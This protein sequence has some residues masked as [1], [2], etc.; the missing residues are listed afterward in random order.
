MAVGGS[1]GFGS[2]SNGAGWIEAS[3]AAH[4]GTAGR[5]GDGSCRRGGARASENAVRLLEPLASL[6]RFRQ[7]PTV[8]VELRY[9]GGR[10]RPAL[11]NLFVGLELAFE[12]PGTPAAKVPGTALRFTARW[13]GPAAAT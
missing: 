7:A 10:V 8:L 13:R 4:G 12:R 6:P 2:R 11:A 5:V 1:G 9:R 3:A